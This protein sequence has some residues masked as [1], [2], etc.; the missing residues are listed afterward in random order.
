MS[1]EQKPAEVPEQPQHEIETSPSGRRFSRKQY[2]VRT[3]D[4][5]GNVHEKKIKLDITPQVRPAGFS[6]V[7]MGTRRS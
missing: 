4:E 3:V 2:T 6:P 5:E 1:E 7:P